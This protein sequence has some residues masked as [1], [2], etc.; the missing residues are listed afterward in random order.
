MAT[1][2]LA[3]HPVH[4]EPIVATCYDFLDALYAFGRLDDYTEG[5]YLNPSTTYEQAQR[6]QHNFLLDQIRCE[7]GSRILDIGC[8]AGTLLEEAERRGARVVGITVSS[9]QVARCRKKGLDVRLLD[10]RDLGHEWNGRFDGIVANG[11]IEH[12]VQPQDAIEGRQ[13]GIYRD[14]FRTCSRLL[15]PRS[16]SKR[17]AT[18]VLHFRGK[19]IDPSVALHNPFSL[20]YGSDEFHYAWLMQS[21]GGYYPVVGQLERCAKR[22]FAL[23]SENDGTEDYYLTSKQWMNRIYAALLRPTTMPFV[24]K[25]IGWWVLHH[26]R[27]VTMGLLAVLLFRSWLWQFQPTSPPMILLRQT[28]HAT[29]R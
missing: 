19:S 1:D 14:L 5:L 15:D 9:A 25:E 27:Q 11:S 16:P 13:D 6:N 17:F 29:E 18:T 20:P 26:P 3:Y 2:L 4:I 10:Y 24:W 12:F 21:M 23:E 28:W 8:G 7:K 22:C